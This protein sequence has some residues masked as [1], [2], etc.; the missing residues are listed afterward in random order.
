M[1]RW[2]PIAM[3]PVVLTVGALSWSVVDGPAPVEQATVIRTA[4]AP[5]HHEDSRDPVGRQ[6]PEPET[7]RPRLPSRGDRALARIERREAEAKE[8]IAALV[9]SGEITEDEA[10]GLRRAAAMTLDDARD[11]AHR[12]QS[13]EI[14]WIGG[15]V[16]GIPVRMRHATYV[17]NVVGYDR[18]KRIGHREDEEEEE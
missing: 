13:G 16:R 5:A 9:Q 3:I 7:V 6:Q 1:R 14:H 15:L 2:A 10:K 18:A 8:R 12:V 17:I 4:S 11:I